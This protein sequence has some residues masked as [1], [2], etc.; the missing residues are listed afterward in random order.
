MCLLDGSAAGIPAS[1]TKI[2]K[3]ESWINSLVLLIDISLY[4]NFPGA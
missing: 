2:N 3:N 4:E 1:P